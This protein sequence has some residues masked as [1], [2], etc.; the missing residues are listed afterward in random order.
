MLELRTRRYGTCAESRARLPRTTAKRY[1]L[2]DDVLRLQE[3]QEK[4]LAVTH[5]IYGKKDLYF[6]NIE[7]KLKKNGLIL[8]DELKTLLHLCQTLADVELAKDVIYRYHIENKNVAFG[9][10]KFGPLFIRLCYE[11]DLESMALDLIKDKVLNGFF[12][13]CT[14]FN[15]LMDMAFSKGHYENALE[16]LIEMK[17]QGIKFSKDTYILAFAIC[18]KLDSAESCKICSLLLEETE[19]K[20][21][22]VPRQAYCFA[23]AFAL[24]QNDVQKARSI[25]SKMTNTE[26]RVCHNLDILIQALSGTLENILNILEAA[27]K[28]VTPKFVKRPEFSEQVLAAVRERV[29]SNPVL[30]CRFNDIYAKLQLSRQVTS[31]T[32]DDMLCQTPSARKHHVL[33]LSQRKISRRTFQ[34]LQSALLVE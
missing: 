12:S 20:G 13:D 16:V 21:D 1:L 4:K 23:V 19:L 3:F 24:K 15:I 17:N 27:V 30:H 11:L 25:Y 26:S 10:F 32:L 9:E 18:Y 33:L 7:E 5:Q 8:R 31:L 34:P 6:K 22:Y 29:R 2:S 28:T 14:S